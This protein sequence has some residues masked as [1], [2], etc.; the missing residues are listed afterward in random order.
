MLQLQGSHLRA[1][2]SSATVQ[3]L[4]S[5][6]VSG[7]ASRPSCLCHDQGFQSG[8]Q[9]AG[10]GRTNLGTHPMGCAVATHLWACRVLCCTQHTTQHPAT[11]VQSSCQ[12]PLV[13]CHL[14][15]SAGSVDALTATE[16]PRFHAD[17][18]DIV[19]LACLQNAASGGARSSAQCCI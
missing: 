3:R 18:A 4:T 6:E 8:L 13:S 19:F 2:K 7:K 9:A 1:S 11:H 14:C 10:G 5:A 15:Q 16:S 17:N 12:L